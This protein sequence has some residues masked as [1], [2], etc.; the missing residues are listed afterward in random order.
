MIRVSKWLISFS[1]TSSLSCFCA[2][3][4]MSR[5]TFSPLWDLRHSY[6]RQSILASLP[7]TESFYHG[8]T[9]LPLSCSIVPSTECMSPSRGREQYIQALQSTA[10]VADPG[11]QPL[12]PPTPAAHVALRSHDGN[13]TT[14][15]ICCQIF[16]ASPALSAF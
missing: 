16:V 14:E 4:A 12:T 13:Q 2:S 7:R 3:L 11:G 9:L 6:R 10:V 8:W 15:Q 5:D 1:T